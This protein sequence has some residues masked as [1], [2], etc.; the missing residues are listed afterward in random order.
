MELQVSVR[1]TRASRVLRRREMFFSLASASGISITSASWFPSPSTNRALKE[2]VS[3]VVGAETSCWVWV[4]SRASLLWRFDGGGR[5]VA[6][7]EV[8][9]TFGSWLLLDRG[10]RSKISRFRMCRHRPSWHPTLQGGVRMTGAISC[11]PP[12]DVWQRLEDVGPCYRRR[13]GAPSDAPAGLGF[14]NDAA[15]TRTFARR[16]SSSGA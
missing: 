11:A 15:N 13:P 4:R 5:T 7:V 8:L 9:V 2:P 12:F 1:L 6:M 14:M 3:V 16:N 10:V